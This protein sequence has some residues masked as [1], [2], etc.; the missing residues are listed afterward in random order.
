MG[1]LVPLMSFFADPYSAPTQS[2]YYNFSDNPHVRRGLDMLTLEE[3]KAG[4]RRLQMEDILRDFQRGIS[5]NLIDITPFT[6]RGR[7]PFAN[8]NMNLSHIYPDGYVDDVDNVVRRL[9]GAA[10][11]GDSNELGLGLSSRYNEF[12]KELADRLAIRALNANLPMDIPEVREHALQRLRSGESL[13]QVAANTRSWILN[14]SNSKSLEEY[15]QNRE[16]NPFSRAYAVLNS[17]LPA[18]V[19]GDLY[20]TNYINEGYYNKDSISK[21]Y[22]DI[23]QYL[24]IAQLAGMLKPQNWLP[25]FIY[26]GWKLP[27]SSRIPGG[28]NFATNALGAAANVHSAIAN[29]SDEDAIKRYIMAEVAKGNNPFEEDSGEF[30]YNALLNTYGLPYSAWVGPGSA[31]NMLNTAKLYLSPAYR[32]KMQ[33]YYKELADSG[34]LTATGAWKRTHDGHILQRSR[35]LSEDT[36]RSLGRAGLL[37]LGIG[38]RAPVIAALDMARGLGVGLSDAHDVFSGKR[39]NAVSR[40]DWDEMEQDLVKTDINPTV[41]AIASSLKNSARLGVNMLH[42]PGK[43]INK[44]V[45]RATDLANYYIGPKAKVQKEI[46]N[47]TSKASDR[48]ATRAQLEEQ[49]RRLRELNGKV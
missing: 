29:L 40:Q 7:S 23:K 26:S 32:K 20:G 11:P 41:D 46:L 16:V 30:V 12:D 18:K 4:L 27:K 5:T 17:T 36:A 47:E 28:F 22:K 49:K 48:K 45:N 3:Q 24:G 8:E 38:R 1:V 10:S 2:S 43:T 33:K 37:A 21:N 6:S 14:T 9:Y 42:S 25:Q 39:K 34:V 31:T 13:D 44:I 15:M 35:S 19:F